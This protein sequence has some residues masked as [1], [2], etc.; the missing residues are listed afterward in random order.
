MATAID[1]T[2]VRP[3]RGPQTSGRTSGGLSEFRLVTCLP[4]ATNG[5]GVVLSPNEY[6]AFEQMLD[7]PARVIPELAA[8][9]R[10]TLPL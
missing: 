1:L 8:L 4:E 7:R 6:A 2:P 3:F 9:L 10:A 5:C